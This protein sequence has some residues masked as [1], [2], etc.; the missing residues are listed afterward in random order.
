MAQNVHVDNA[1][2]FVRWL[3]YEFTP[4]ERL[5]RKP[6]AEHG[7]PHQAWLEQQGLFLYGHAKGPIWAMGEKAGLIGLRFDSGDAGVVYLTKEQAKDVIDQLQ[8]VV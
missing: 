3:K 2:Y 8:A 7:K 1:D 5:E 4:G 6:K